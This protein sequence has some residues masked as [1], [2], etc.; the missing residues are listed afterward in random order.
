METFKKFV[1]TSIKNRINQSP[2]GTYSQMYDMIDAQ[3]ADIEKVIS[4]AP[5]ELLQRGWSIA[6]SLEIPVE[7]ITLENLEEI[8]LEIDWLDYNYKREGF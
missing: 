8:A 1:N 7:E 3:I 2:V 6:I 4:E 5:V